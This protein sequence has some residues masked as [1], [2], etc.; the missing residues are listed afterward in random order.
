MGIMSTEQI[1]SS[2][3]E[4][5]LVEHAVFVLAAL[6]GGVADEY[7][8]LAEQLVRE[9]IWIVEQRLAESDAGRIESLPWTKSAAVC[10]GTE[11]AAVPF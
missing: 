8:Q 1:L 2:L 6:E 9:D 3:M 10:S 4:L 5:P 7:E 11:A